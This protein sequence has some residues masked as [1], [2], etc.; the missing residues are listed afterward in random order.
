MNGFVFVAAVMC[1]LVLWLIL[2]PLLSR[3]DAAA[4]PQADQLNLAVL[5]DQLRE[6][7]AD[8]EQGSI[9][10][11]AYLVARRELEQRVAEDVHPAA[12]PA[13]SA[14]GASTP[15]P[16][17][18]AAAL[19]LVLVAG[20]GMLYASLG[21]PQALSARGAAATVAAGQAL[22]PHTSSEAEAM[23]AKLAERMAREP[24]DPNGWALLARS[25]SA[26]GRFVAASGAYARLVTLIPDDAQVLSDYADV[27]AM[28]Q[29]QK[30]AGE[31]ERLLKRALAADPKNVKALILSGDAA[32]ERADHAAAAIHWQ[33]ALANAAPN[34][35][36]AQMARDN[37]AHIGAPAEGAAVTAPP[38]AAAPAVA[39]S[40]AAA[41]AISGSVELD[42]ALRA[43]V[44]DGDTVF[45][46]AKAADG[47]RFP[48]A[49]LRKQVRDLPLQFTLDDS[50]GMMP[51]VTL[52]QFDQLVVTA[53]I[54]KSGNA[55]AAPG[56]LE[57][58]P[59]PA[60]PGQTRIQLRI[61]PK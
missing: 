38:A 43:Q 1:V 41:T 14:A 26:M 3:R 18:Q 9:D 31:P 55:I 40:P 4:A 19:A 50:M 56:D 51:G 25:Y 45:I 53:R 16:R 60:K 44:A 20:A 6:L 35:E 33:A 49:V 12:T 58:P 57:S 24:Q 17:W 2:R 59:Q 8:R 23:V 22:D 13:A 27:L 39:T 10:A 42:P 5:R 30:L 61:S 47:P 54:S 36:F 48:L 21:T 37:L 29:N 32:F 11:E 46:V 7:E 15:A 34:S 52:S 28:T